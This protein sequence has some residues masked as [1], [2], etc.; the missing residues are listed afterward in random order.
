MKRSALAVLSALTMVLVGGGCPLSLLDNNTVVNVVE[1]TLTPFVVLS[2]SA[3]AGH[4]PA[5]TAAISE[6]NGQATVTASLS[7]AAAADVTIDLEFSGTTGTADYTP[8]ANQIVI[9]AGQTS[10]SITLTAV[11][12]TVYEGSE[13]ITVGI[14][15]VT[16]AV[17]ASTGQQV[18][19]TITDDEQAPTVDLSLT[20]SPLAENGGVAT[21][22]ATLSNASTQPVT[23]SLDFGGTA[24]TS[25][26]VASATQVTIPA[27]QTSGSITLTGIADNV[28]EGDKTVIVILGGVTNGT[29][30]T[31][32][33]VTATINDSAAQ[34]TVSLSP[35]AATIPENGGQATVTATLSEASSK[36]T[37]VSLAFTGTATA[38]DYTHSGSQI[39]IPAGQTTG[40]LTITSLDDT[41]YE[42][43][44][45]III[46]ITGVTNAAVGA[47]GR[48]TI[49]ILDDD[50]PPTVSLSL[51]GSPLAE[52]GGIAT[53]T[54]TLSAISGFATTVDLG[55]AGTAGSGDYNSSANQIVIPA[56]QISGS[57]TLTGI[58]DTLD[59][60]DE[61]II[62]SIT[63]ATNATVGATSQVTATIH[64]SAPSPTLTLAVDN[65]TI[66]ESGGVATITATLSKAAFAQAEIPF[67]FSGTAVKDTNYTASDTKIVI[68]VGQTTGTLTLTAVNDGIYRGDLSITASAGTPQNAQPASGQTGQLTVTIHEAQAV[69]SITLSPATFVLPENAGTAS[70]TATLSG[71]V[72]QDTNVSFGLAGTA[73]NGTDYTVS[74]TSITI[75][76]G[77]LSGSITL[78]GVNDTTYEGSKTIIVSITGVSG[79]VTVA[80]GVQEADGTLIDSLSVPKVTLSLSGSPFAEA[81]GAAQVIA[82]LSNRTYVDVTVA[83]GLG[84]TAVQDAD[85]TASAA[86]V[87]IPKGSLSR[88]IT[89][90]GASN[91]VPVGDKTIVVDITAVTNGVEDGVQQVTATVTD[92]LPM[93]TLSKTGSP[94][95]DQ[96][97]TTATV[98]ATMSKASATDVTIGFAFGGSATKDTDYTASDTQIVIPAGQT[99]GNSITLTLIG[100]NKYNAP[101]TIVLTGQQPPNATY[102]GSN[103]VTID[104]SATTDLQYK[105]KC[106]A[107]LTQ[108]A[109][110]AGVVVLPDGL[111]YK[112]INAGSGDPPKLTDQVYV[113]YT[114]TLIDGT[115]FDQSSGATFN[116]T[117]VIA[118]WTE[119]LQL[120][121]L[122]AKWMLYIPYDLAYGQNGSSP[123]IPPY[124]ALVFEVE[125]LGIHS[126]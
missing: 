52:N 35:A 50:P 10:G 17:E 70:L 94:M 22:T 97:G 59:E 58:S 18:T 126:P 99:T 19:I 36:P 71:P 4:T 121:P 106:E 95:A 62:V 67:T 43:D 32:T 60:G 113:K 45:T 20:G 124:A 78:T 100:N 65:T 105:A 47:T 1:N 26:Y 5:S 42:P 66:A 23:A 13:T 25:D 37:T 51:S 102:A 72:G 56:G 120:M 46:D 31:T 64:D 39:V 57:I 16:G 49:T 111:Q 7:G 116:V 15:S 109:T 107:W 89:L 119:A 110:Q 93:V 63:G 40:T 14:A 98:S 91:P 33:Q 82:T 75:P 48:T 11:Q 8:S 21:V 86:Q 61:T 29:R 28:Y 44:E 73:T 103:Q 108:N 85:Y 3:A 122:S 79:G 68:P 41:I 87:V 74:A 30:G 69:P 53:V 101:G 6:N 104:L 83:L 12:D 114:G 90:V 38:S 118:G 54:A 76:S 9:P 77:Q 27:G 115:V 55:F 80:G 96:A 117:G 34:P 84:G 81:G 112:V 24:A 88:A 92:N 2:V 125:L 123:T